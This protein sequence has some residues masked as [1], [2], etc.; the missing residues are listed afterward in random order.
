MG[1]FRFFTQY[2]SI[3]E[4]QNHRVAVLHIYKLQN[5][6]NTGLQ[7]NRITERQNSS[8]TALQCWIF[9]NISVYS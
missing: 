1:F 6:R 9:K 8:M 7:N 4:L 2:Y 3:T 5:Y